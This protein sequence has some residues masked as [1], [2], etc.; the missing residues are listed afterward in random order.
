[1]IRRRT[2]FQG[3]WSCETVLQERFDWRYLCAMLIGY[4]RISTSTRYAVLIFLLPDHVRIPLILIASLPT[5][6]EDA[7]M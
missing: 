3:L 6:C 1:M 2:C 5:L 7:R 4:A